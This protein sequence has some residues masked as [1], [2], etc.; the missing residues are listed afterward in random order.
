MYKYDSYKSWGQ[1]AQRDQTRPPLEEFAQDRFII[2]DQAFVKEDIERYRAIG[3][4]HFIM[5]CQWPGLEHQRV[6]CSIR[7]LGEI[8]A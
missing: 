8:F 1:H 3:V 7:A 5:R 6:L 4:N 2:G